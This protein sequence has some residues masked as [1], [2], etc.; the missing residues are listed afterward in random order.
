MYDTRH[1][2][3]EARETTS[4]Q[5]RTSASLSCRERDR[6]RDRGAAERRGMSSVRLHATTDATGEM[7]PPRRGAARTLTAHGRPTPAGRGPP[8][9]GAR[10]QVKYHSTDGT[11][12]PDGD[13]RAG[14]LKPNPSEGKVLPH[15]SARRDLDISPDARVLG[16]TSSLGRGG[17][18]YAVF[19]GL[20]GLF[21]YPFF[22]F[23]P[24]EEGV[25]V[26]RAE[27]D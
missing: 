26:H 15:Y 18:V 23:L 5:G 13:H 17:R 21:F 1:A 16:P 3:S 7:T 4:P 24:S 12:S 14:W 6:R 8:P 9:A 19:A 10:S 11:A 27:E 20:A 25:G 22:F 2:I